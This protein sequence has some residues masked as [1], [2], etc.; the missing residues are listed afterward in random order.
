MLLSRVVESFAF[1]SFTCLSP[2]TYGGDK[3]IIHS[4]CYTRYEIFQAL[5]FSSVW[6]VIHILAQHLIVSLR[7]LSSV[8]TFQTTTEILWAFFSFLTLRYLNKQSC[9]TFHLRTPSFFCV[10]H[11]DLVIHSFSFSKGDRHRNVR[12]FIF[13]LKATQFHNDRQWLS[14]ISFYFVIYCRYYYIILWLF[15]YIN[16]IFVAFEFQKRR[17]Y[18][19][20]Q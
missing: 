2:K 16:W 15:Q 17:H 1:I 6:K 18:F 19:I 8:V 11:I 5:T 7:S 3:G 12:F 4:K 20:Y 13:L 9:R 10:L 14:I